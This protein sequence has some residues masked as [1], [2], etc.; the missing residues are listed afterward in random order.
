LTNIASTELQSYT[1]NNKVSLKLTNVKLPKLK[2]K[3]KITKTI[4]H[5][6]AGAEK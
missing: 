5:A 6:C 2:L 1:K 3:I 4:R